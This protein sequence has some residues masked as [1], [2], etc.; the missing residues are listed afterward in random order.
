M[1]LARL[2]GAGGFR[3]TVAIK[4]LHPHLAKERSFIEMFLDEARLASRIHHPNVVPI[5]EIGESERGHFVVMDYIEGASAAAV[6]GARSGKRAPTPVSVRVVLDALLGLHAAHELVSDDGTPLGLVHRDVSPHNILVGTDGASRLTDFGVAR[7]ASR[8]TNTQSGHVKGK[9]AYMAPEQAAGAPLDRRADIFAMGIVLWEA[10]T[11]IRLFKRETD[12]ETLTRLLYE[13]IAEAGTLNVDVT[14]ELDAVVMKSL[15]RDPQKRYSTAADFAEALEVAAR[16]SGLVG[17]AKAVAAEVEEA[18]SE[19]IT[20]H[21][22]L[23]C[24]RR[25]SHFSLLDYVPNKWDEPTA[26]ETFTPSYNGANRAL[27]GTNASSIIHVGGI[28]PTSGPGRQP[29]W[30]RGVLIGVSVAS[31]ALALAALGI[32]GRAT[33]PADALGAVAAP[34]IVRAQP[35]A[36]TESPFGVTTASTEGTAVPVAAVANVDAAAPTLS[37]SAKRGVGHATTPSS[38]AKPQTA[39]PGPAPVATSRPIDDFANPYR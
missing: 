10:L 32:S 28:R 27:E 16:G 7:A 26:T 22:D 37:A 24:N 23:V 39:P 3:R 30:R 19:A 6:V 5:V 35:P 31:V 13:P 18:A 33:A 14:P 2:S 9:L 8:L 4:R 11:G 17:S 36:Q 21:R 1:Y 38:M 25:V 29:S 34:Q 12:V 20:A 15:E